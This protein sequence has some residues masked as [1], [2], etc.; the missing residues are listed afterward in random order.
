MYRSEREAS[1]RKT[2]NEVSWY[3]LQVMNKC[4]LSVGNKRVKV[5]CAF[6]LK[7]IFF[8]KFHLSKILHNIHVSDQV[9]LSPQKILI[10]SWYPSVSW[11]V[12]HETLVVWNFAGDINHVAQHVAMLSI[13]SFESQKGKLKRKVFSSISAWLFH[14]FNEINSQ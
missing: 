10:L 8:E 2:T 11:I 4:R 1:E 5:L 14:V 13:V 3:C 7:T 9:V 12:I 6:Q